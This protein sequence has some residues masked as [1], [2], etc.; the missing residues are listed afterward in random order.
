[1]AAGVKTTASAKLNSSNFSLGRPR[2]R[3]VEIV[4]PER[5]NPRKARPNALD[6]ANQQIGML[7]LDFAFARRFFLLRGPA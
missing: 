7:R 6:Q 1:M 3:P 4:E 5:E 2:S